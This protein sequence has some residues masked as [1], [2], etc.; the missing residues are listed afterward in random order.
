MKETPNH[1]ERT[2]AR[3]SPSGAHRWIA[4]PGSIQAEEGCPEE[5]TEAA[6]E[7]TTAHEVCEALLTGAPLPQGAT[8]EMI[9]HATKYRDYIKGIITHLKDEKPEEEVLMAIEKKVYPSVSRLPEC[10][11]TCD[12][13]VI[14]PSELHIIDY[15]YGKGVRVTAEKNPQAMIYALGALNAYPHLNP[16]HVCMHIYQPRVENGLS[17]FRV[18]ADWLR[19]WGELVLTPAAEAT[20]EEDAP[21]KAGKHCLFCKAKS[22][23][24]TRAKSLFRGLPKRTETLTDKQVAT[25]CA[26]A[27][28]IRSWLDGVTDGA[29]ERMMTGEQIEGLRLKAGR[30]TRSWKEGASVAETLKRWMPAEQIYTLI[31]PAQA[32]KIIGKKD[33]DRIANEDMVVEKRTRPT[34]SVDKEVPIDYNFIKEVFNHE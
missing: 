33:F 23:C 16:A 27:P 6:D 5:T 15:K 18:P 9:H 8:E 28:E 32:E 22:D 10:W 3:L 2:H 20:D 25:V 13:L 7:G 26:K 14:S 12:S 31:S 34:V 30:A 17:I 19:A 24:L 21:R 29:R 11:G 1:T 4:C